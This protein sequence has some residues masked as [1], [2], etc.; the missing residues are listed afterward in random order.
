MK[1]VTLSNVKKKKQ[2]TTKNKQNANTVRALS[3]PLLRRGA[4]E[5][6]RHKHK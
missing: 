6:L 1:S 5:G 4:F 2:K 3:E